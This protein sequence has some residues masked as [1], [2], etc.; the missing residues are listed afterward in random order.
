MCHLFE[1][2]IWLLS[3]CIIASHDD[4]PRFPVS[5]CKFYLMFHLV[6][7]PSLPSTSF[8]FVRCSWFTSTNED[9][10]TSLEARVFLSSALLGYLNHFGWCPSREYL[11]SMKFLN[12][13]FSESVSNEFIAV[14][15]PSIT[16]DLPLIQM[17][18]T[19]NPPQMNSSFLDHCR[20]LMSFWGQ[21]APSHVIKSIHPS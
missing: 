19:V 7:F 17:T 16:A 5:V 8:N 4:H 13:L 21:S 6:P 12:L 20:F 18:S 15:Y 11:V 9:M 14:F 1:N 2:E 3:S 10:R